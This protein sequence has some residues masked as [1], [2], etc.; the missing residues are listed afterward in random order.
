MM[1]LSPP[2]FLKYCLQQLVDKAPMNTAM[3][4]DVLNPVN[5]N[6]ERQRHQEVTKAVMLV[7]CK[8]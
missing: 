2:I 7:S 4:E 8:P 1:A 3:V 6:F 5:A